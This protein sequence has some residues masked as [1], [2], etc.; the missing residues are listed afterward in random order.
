[1]TIN[2][3]LTNSDRQ[4]YQ[5]LI[6][7]MY[8]KIPD[9]MSRKIPKANV[10]QAFGID[11][12]L[13]ELNE[14]KNIKEMLCVGAFEDTTLAYLES[15]GYAIEKIDPL[16]NTDLHTFLNRNVT[17]QYDII[18]SISVIEH[19]QNDNEFIQDICKLLKSNGLAVLTCDFK[20]NYIIGDPLISTCYRFYTKKDLYHRLNDIIIL[21]NCN[22]VDTP[23]WEDPPDF[24]LDNN[25]YSFATFVF[26]KKSE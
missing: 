24:V 12:V 19:V 2:K 14:H 7:K 13:N 18:F 5:D 10:Q 1:M 9:M 4:H 15:L 21:N 6:L 22:L 8:E 25:I 11:I 16:I 20:D 26:R 23:N 3:I 17:K